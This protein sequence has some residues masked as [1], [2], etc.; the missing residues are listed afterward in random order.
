MDYPVGLHS[1]QK[2][3]KQQIS[4]L[5]KKK[6]KIVYIPKVKEHR[7]WG[8]YLFFIIM[9]FFSCDLFSDSSMHPTLLSLRENFPVR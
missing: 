9:T 2:R 3:W 6:K 1:K 8:I 5:E 7:I 4:K